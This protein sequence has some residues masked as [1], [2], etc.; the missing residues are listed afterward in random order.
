M[1]SFTRPGKLPQLAPLRTRLTVSRLRS[2]AALSSQPWRAK[3]GDEKQDNE[4]DNDEQHGVGGPSRITRRSAIVATTATTLW[5]AIE[6]R[7]SR[8]IASAAESYTSTTEWMVSDGDSRLVVRNDG[9]LILLGSGPNA[10]PQPLSV[11]LPPSSAVAK[12]ARRC[13][14]NPT[15]SLLAVEWPEGDLVIWPILQ[16]S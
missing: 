10:I 5:Q 2:N 15:G 6:T 8:R 12:S 9:R 16:N 1:A 7:S 14:F 3:K 4:Q 13:R 11:S